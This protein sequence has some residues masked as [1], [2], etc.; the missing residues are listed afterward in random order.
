MEPQKPTPSSSTSNSIGA[1]AIW[2]LLLAGLA[3]FFNYLLGNIYNP[4][5]KVISYVTE[6]GQKEVALIRNRAG[7]YLAN[8]EINGYPVTFLL[9]TGATH[10]SIPE[11]VAQRIGLQRGQPIRAQTAN[12]VITTYTT[13]LDNVSIGNI[14]MQDIRGGIN[15]FM[16]GENI[17]LGMSFLKHLTLTQR[18]DTLTL[19]AP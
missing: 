10:V 7:H 13:N 5:K 4:N 16:K 15:P 11:R 3:I 14:A 1:I 17:L 6:T 12:G 2:L 18:N 8:G 19:S 9:D